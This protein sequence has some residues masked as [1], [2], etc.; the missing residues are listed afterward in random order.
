M[1]YIPKK[2]KSLNA[3]VTR[4]LSIDTPV[5]RVSNP[6]GREVL[7]FSPPNEETTIEKYLVLELPAT[8]L[9]VPQV[10]SVDP[11][12]EEWEIEEGK[13]LT[14]QVSSGSL[15]ANLPPYEK[16]V[17]WMTSY[18][19]AKAAAEIGRKD[20][21]NAGPTVFKGYDESTGRGSLILGCLGVNRFA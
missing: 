21:I 6:S 2:I 18:P 5:K 19:T 3:H 16:G 10:G 20:F 1:V 8:D 4:I 15:I 14:V 12:L 17:V 7:V 13:K 11:T 9:P